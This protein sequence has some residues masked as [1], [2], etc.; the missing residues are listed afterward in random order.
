MQFSGL[1]IAAILLVP[2]ALF[3]QHTSGASG[4]SSGS[5][6]S[7]SVSSSSSSSSSGSHASGSKSSASSG[8]SHG[9]N[10]G[11]SHSSA[12]SGSS[13]NSSSSASHVAS[14]RE[15]APHAA[16][17]AESLSAKKTAAPEKKS[18]FSFFRHPFRRAKP[19][20]TAEAK[21]PE[22]CR[23]KPCPV[24]PPGESL[25]GKGACAAPPT[26]VARNRKRC[27]AGTVWN[28]VTCGDYYEDPCSSARMAAEELNKIQGQMESVCSGN[29]F[30]QEC[31]DF[32]QRYEGALQSYESL[33][34]GSPANCQATLRDPHSL[35][36]NGQ[37]N[38]S[39]PKRDIT[40]APP[41]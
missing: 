9:S 11:G 17:T 32:K 8:G 21:R 37:G 1:V 29:S 41:K 26:A 10:S 3:S 15:T 6:S 23:K 14:K 5:S 36:L 34:R 30:G 12:S 7:T 24:C 35:G 20:Q 19:V 40:P 16:P 13:H 27:G 22:P 39:S 28:G 25:N 33:L 4:S 18:V 2:A 38:P 31:S